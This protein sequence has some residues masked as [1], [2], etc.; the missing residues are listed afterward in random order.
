MSVS[1]AFKG[2][3]KISGA[4]RM[5]IFEVAEK[6][7]YVPNQAARQLRTGKTDIVGFI[8]TDLANPFH[9]MMV[10]HAESAFNE[11]G[12]TLFSGGSNWQ[13]KREL[14]FAE[15]LI[16]MQAR[17]VLICPCEKNFAAFELLDKAGIP[18]VALDSVPDFYRGPCVVNDLEQCGRLMAEHFHQ[19]G[20]RS[21]A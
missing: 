10:K 9:S 2:S 8:V 13:E 4:T 14:A 11:M 19:T 3:P 15:R 21:P 6:L 5:R 17:G 20:A 1:L 12:L 16:R 7:N 18:Y